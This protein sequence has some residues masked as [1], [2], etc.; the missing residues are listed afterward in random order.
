MFK[1]IQEDGRIPNS[2]HEASIILIPKPDKFTT[3]KENFR[4]IL[5]MGKNKNFP[6]EIRNHTRL[7]IFTTSTQYSIGSLSHTIQTRK[8]NKGTQ[9]GKEE[10]KLSLF[11]DDMIVYIKK[12]PL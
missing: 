9:I 8:G 6:T 12:N 7:P 11:A 2:V 10:T 3:K 1:K 4:P 5:L